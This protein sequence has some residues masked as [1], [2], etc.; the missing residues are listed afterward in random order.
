MPCA[1]LGECGIC[2]INTSTGSVHRLQKDYKLT[3][4]DGP[5]FDLKMLLE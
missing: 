2:A 5:V 1:G 3:C 4:K